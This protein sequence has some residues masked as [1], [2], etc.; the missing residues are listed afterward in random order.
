MDHNYRQ[1]LW[2]C[3][4]AA[5]D[6][7]ITQLLMYCLNLP[8][9]PGYLKEFIRTRLSYYNYIYQLNMTLNDVV[10]CIGL[11]ELKVEWTNLFLSS[12]FII[13]ILTL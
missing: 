9:L 8:D 10:L 5:R 4:N 12:Y 13:G 1:V 7:N 6:S 11:H 2:L 3:Q